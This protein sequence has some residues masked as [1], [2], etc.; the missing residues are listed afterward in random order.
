MDRSFCIDGPADSFA[1]GLEAEG[2][3]EDARFCDSNEERD[4][5]GR[6]FG[7]NCNLDLGILTISSTLGRSAGSS[8]SSF[9]SV[10]SIEARGVSILA[11]L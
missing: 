8:S 6:C 3:R 7:K 2:R 4:S 1:P 10:P 9:S 11:R 5:E